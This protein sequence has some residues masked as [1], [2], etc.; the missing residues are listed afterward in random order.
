[1]E[2]L[3]AELGEV[4]AGHCAK[5]GGDALRERSEEEEQ[6]GGSISAEYLE[7]EAKHG[8]PEGDPEEAVAPHH[9][10]PGPGNYRLPFPPLISPH[11]RSDSIFPGSR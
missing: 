11:L 6:T 9:T 8:G 10:R 1:M 3:V 4:L 2:V 5:P 7:D